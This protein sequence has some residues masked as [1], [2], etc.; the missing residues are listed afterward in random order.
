MPLAARGC[1]ALPTLR[2]RYHAR[3][4]DVQPFSFFTFVA[5]LGGWALYRRPFEAR[6][7]S[8]RSVAAAEERPPP[9]P[10]TPARRP[11]SGSCGTIPMMMRV[12]P[13][14]RAAARAMTR[15]MATATRL[16]HRRPAACVTTP[17]MT[18]TTQ[19]RHA[20]SATIL[21]T[22]MP[23]RRANGRP[24]LTVT[25]RRPA[26]APRATRTTLRRHGGRGYGNFDVV[27]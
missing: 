11:G 3:C 8:P 1:S 9:R 27:L 17:M 4:A 25:P 20:H 15:L 14:R 7:R 18:T 13:R 26:A 23:R 5:V 16:T 19:P 22:T 2:S 24:T 21:T 12:T 6:T 10:S